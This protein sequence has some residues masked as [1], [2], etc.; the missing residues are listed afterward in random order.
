MPGLGIG[1][2][3]PPPG[4]AMVRSWVWFVLR[5]CF[6]TSEVESPMTDTFSRQHCEHSLMASPPRVTSAP[7]SHR[8]RNACRP[9]SSLHCIVYCQRQTRRA[10]QLQASRICV[11]VKSSCCSSCSQ[12]HPTREHPIPKPLVGQA[13]HRHCC[14][15]E[16]HSTVP[17]DRGPPTPS[18]FCAALLGPPPPAPPVS[19]SRFDAPSHAEAVLDSVATG[20]CYDALVTFQS[21]CLCI[22]LALTA[23][24]PRQTRRI[25]QLGCP[26]SRPSCVSRKHQRKPRPARLHRNT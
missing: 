13:R 15:W 9:A 26:M 18:A 25:C 23:L 16:G 1:A 2:A 14:I 3:W 11:A 19:P 4:N 8:I 5:E 6:A 7:P 20:Q 10:R 12:A 17:T 22:R 21:L 24:A